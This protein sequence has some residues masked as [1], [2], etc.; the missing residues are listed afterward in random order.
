[1][2]R[3]ISIGKH[4]RRERGVIEGDAEPVRRLAVETAVA[5]VAFSR[6]RDR[7][8]RRQRLSARAAFDISIHVCFL[9][10]IFPS[11]DGPRV[12]MTHASTHVR[13]NLRVV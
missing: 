13:R 3:A 11:I 10:E 4:D 5:T 8:E 7:L 6:N 2:L 9:S 1:V 12:I